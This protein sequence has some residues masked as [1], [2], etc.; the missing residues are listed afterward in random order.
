[1]IALV[2][3]VSSKTKQLCARAVLNLI[4]D[5]NIAALK[6]SGSTRIFGAIANSSSAVIQGIC[7]QG[8]LLMSTT[9]ERR[10]DLVTRRPVLQALFGMTRSTSARSRVFVGMTICNILASKDSMKAAIAGGA[11]PVLK[12]IATQ[13]VEE[14]REAA[15]RTIVSLAQVPVHAMKLMECPL[16]QILVLIMQ[17]GN[18]FTLEC[19]INALSA[20]SQTNLYHIFMI[21]EGAVP[22][23]VEAV[24]TGRIATVQC[25]TEAIRT[26]YMLS[27]S[28][29]RMQH[30]VAK[31]HV[32]VTLHLLYKGSLYCAESAEMVALIVRN[33]SECPVA[34]PYII[35]EGGLLLL[36]AILSCTTNRS[37]AVARSVIITI[38]NLSKQPALH[39]QT[40]EQGCLAMLKSVTM[41]DSAPDATIPEKLINADLHSRTAGMPEDSLILTN[42]DCVRVAEA[43]RLMSVSVSAREALAKANVVEIFQVFNTNHEMNE[44]CRAAVAVALQNIASH[45]PCVTLLVAQGTAD[46]LL[47]VSKASSTPTTQS[48]CQLALGQI[49]GVTKVTTGTVSSLLMLTLEKEESGGGGGGSDRDVI[50]AL[51]KSVLVSAADEPKMDSSQGKKEGGG[52]GARNLRQMI[53]EGMA[54]GRVHKAL[55]TLPAETP[56]APQKTAPLV[57]ISESEDGASGAEAQRGQ[58]TPGDA[59]DDEEEHHSRPKMLGTIGRIH[60]KHGLALTGDA[61]DEV[62]TGASGTNATGGAGAGA[63]SSKLATSPLKKFSL[64]G[65]VGGAKFK[66]VA[67]SIVAF[68]MASLEATVKEMDQFEHNNS[69]FAYETFQF[70]TPVE[71]GGVVTKRDDVESNSGLP[72]LSPGEHLLSA[73]THDRTADMA[74]LTVNMT[75]LAKDLRVISDFP[76]VPDKSKQ[77]QAAGEGLGGTAGGELQPASS[78]LSGSPKPQSRQASDVSAIVSRRK[79]SIIMQRSQMTDQGLMLAKPVRDVASPLLGEKSGA[80][81]PA[82]DGLATTAGSAT[83]TGTDTGAGAGTG[84]D[85]N[86]AGVASSES[87]TGSR[88]DHPGPR[89]G[90]WAHHRLTGTNSPK[91]SP[92]TTGLK[93]FSGQSSPI[94]PLSRKSPAI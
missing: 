35:T 93:T 17:H 90:A 84:T 82:P 79:N 5:E 89:G 26:L 14:L 46:L 6:E 47:S 50:A 8:F 62:T 27:Y 9:Q 53:R 54:S 37:V 23:I 2:R 13:E 25:A 55:Q 61:G 49:S 59:A 88:G 43:I 3:S 70:S 12:M 36:R 22:G 66:E 52:G 81:S 29:S 68:D 87:K 34:L 11:L 57:A 31:C 41:G 18:S 30:I 85:G 51:R 45:K 15:A 73:G 4:T 78:V 74:K 1:M 72:S 19:A 58:V 38:L 76:A 44:D 39:D 92:K 77:E 16:V 20:L 69:S 67:K 56:A 71:P 24:F 42:T 64:K 83:G 32:L 75:P 33:A 94:A 86:A 60:T 65:L 21:D 80:A 48:A 28:A 7:A 10:D 63:S 40:I 91:N